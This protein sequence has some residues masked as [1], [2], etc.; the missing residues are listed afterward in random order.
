MFRFFLMLSLSVAVGS[1][2]PAEDWSSF[3]DGGRVS[4]DHDGVIDPGEVQWLTDLPGYGQSAPIVWKNQV[5]VTTVEGDQKDSCHVTV[6]D[7]KSG[8]RLWQYTVPSASPAPNSSMVSRAAPSPAADQRGIVCLFEG[9]NVIALN[10]EGHVRWQR[11]LVDDYGPIEARHGLSSSLEQNQNSVFIWIER[12]DEPYLLSLSKASGKTEWKSP[13]LGS[14][15][16]STPRL[17]PVRQGHHLVLS[18][19]GKLAGYDP[20]SGEQLWLFEAI[21]GNTVPTPQ[22]LGGGRFL[23]GATVGRGETGGHRAPESNGILQIVQSADGRWSADYVWKA[24]RATSSF[25]SPIVHEGVAYFVNREG[26]VYGL[27]ARTG[28]ERFA[29]RLTGSVWATPIGIGPQVFFFCRD[30]RANRLSE[31]LTGPTISTWDRLP[32]PADRE[33][34]A[35]ATDGPAVGSAGAVLYAASW[36]G[37]RLL[38]R[39]GNRLAAVALQTQ[40]PAPV[41]ADADQ[42]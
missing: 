14:T 25:A 22:P 18:G 11:N 29:K 33:Q 36:C 35:R 4:R 17:V 10:H 7:L 38:L 23:I 30:G 6:L 24:K 5:Y 42:P 34:P 3:Q 28:Q 27:D 32:E 26:V 15:S 2:S 39:Q 41:E 40:S 19:N 8:K 9:G 12:S 21:H 16:W 1:S 13:G 37:N 31:P 20:D